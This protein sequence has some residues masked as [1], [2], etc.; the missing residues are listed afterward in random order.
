[1]TASQSV[2]LD[3]PF[4][5]PPR[6]GEAGE[7]APNILWLRMPL[8]FALDH[9]NLWM[10][11]ES[12]AFTQVDCGYG[13]T[14]TRELWTRHFDTTLDGRPIAHIVATHCH[15]D[16]LGNANGCRTVSAPRSR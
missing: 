6:A 10:L 7:V 12:S 5:A 4:D 11:R 15:P 2:A 3:Y 8:P 1:M 9:I 13:D 16:H 14:A